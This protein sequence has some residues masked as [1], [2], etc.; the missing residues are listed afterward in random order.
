MQQ[1]GFNL[2]GLSVPGINPLAAGSWK[3]SEDA[4]RGVGVPRLAGRHLGDL[5]GV[6]LS[7]AVQLY[8]NILTTRAAILVLTD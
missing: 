6:I 5:R 7:Q 2:L 3:T 8:F 1:R 4:R